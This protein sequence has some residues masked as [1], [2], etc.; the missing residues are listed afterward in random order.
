MVG[1]H[2]TFK[3]GDFPGGWFIIIVKETTLHGL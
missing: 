2:T 3:N 1:K